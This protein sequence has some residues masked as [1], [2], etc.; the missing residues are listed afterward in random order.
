MIVIT[1]PS[2][3]KKL[4][5]LACIVLIAASFSIGFNYYKNMNA[6]VE[7]EEMFEDPI[8]SE[9]ELTEGVSQDQ[10][11]QVDPEEQTDVVENDQVDEACEDEETQ[12]E[13]S[14]ATELEEEFEEKEVEKGF[15]QKIL[16]KFRKE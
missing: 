2:W 10:A 12:E 16:E 1:I 14:D 8:G 6:G 7:F 3:R 11:T 13:S 9:T 5:I 4:I 15:W